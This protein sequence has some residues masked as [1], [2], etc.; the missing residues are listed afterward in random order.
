MTIYHL[1]TN[2]GYVPWCREPISYVFGVN[3]RKGVGDTLVYPDQWCPKCKEI[4]NYIR[5]TVDQDPGPIIK[6]QEC[7]IVESC[8]NGSG[9]EKITN[10]RFPGTYS[11]FWEG[12]DV[13][14][15]KE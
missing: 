15:G 5:N 13:V 12:S 3:Y 14:Y 9:L 10:K 8:S 4:Y 2:D 1:T 6:L 11:E 7:S